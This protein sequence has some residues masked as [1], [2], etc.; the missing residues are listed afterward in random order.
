MQEW[1]TWFRATAGTLN[2]EE[3]DL[4]M[5]EMTD[6]ADNMV[7]LIRCTRLAAEADTLR[8]VL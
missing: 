8:S 2:P 7:A 3:F 4:V 1:L 5:T 6:A